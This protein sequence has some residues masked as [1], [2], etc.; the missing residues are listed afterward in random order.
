MPQI[1]MLRPSSLMHSPAF[2]HVA[3]VPP[4]ATWIL[5]G[6]QNGV[7]VSGQILEP[8]DAAA[9]ARRALANI[10]MALE[11]AGS[12]LTDA[13]MFSVT[14]V[15]GVDLRA[16]YGAIASTLAAALDRPPLVSVAVVSSLAVPG[17][18]VEVALTA[19]RL[20]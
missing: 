5:V 18:L 11:A 15:E 10:E 14:C 4:G 19:A 2:S 17:A 1:T 3:V 12:S 7:D 8:G 6:G 9:Q 16:A 20:P 13:V